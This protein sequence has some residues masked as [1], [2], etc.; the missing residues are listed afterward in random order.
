M[1]NMLQRLLTKLF[2]MSE[3]FTRL[4][5]SY[6]QQKE[7]EDRENYEVA[8]RASGPNLNVYLRYLPEKDE[9]LLKSIPDRI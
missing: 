8:F 1:M 5:N 2:L 6:V 9:I 7:D 3:D 4:Y